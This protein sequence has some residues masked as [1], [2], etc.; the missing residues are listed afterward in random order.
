MHDTGS[1]FRVRNPTAKISFWC[2]LYCILYDN[3]RHFLIL[4]FLLCSL[5]WFLY[6]IIWFLKKSVL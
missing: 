1:E 3:W 2:F 6:Y 4:F 5:L